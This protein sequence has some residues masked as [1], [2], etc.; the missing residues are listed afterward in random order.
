MKSKFTYYT[1]YINSILCYR[2][3]YPS[4]KKQ[5]AV[6]MNKYKDLKFIYRPYVPQILQNAKQLKNNKSD[7]LIFGNLNYSFN[8]NLLEQK[9]T[10]E[11]KKHSH[12]RKKLI[13]ILKIKQSTN[14][15]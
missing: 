11:T 2:E 13:P 7:K 10:I 4:P 3:K 9:S 14:I 1:Y 5:T 15:V 8:Q 12:K 6:S